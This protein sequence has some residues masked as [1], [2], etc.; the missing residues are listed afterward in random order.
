L[1]KNLKK[2]F[3][4]GIQHLASDKYSVN[5]VPAICTLCKNEEFE[6]SSLKLSSSI[7]DF[8]GMG[9]FKETATALIC[10]NCGQLMS[11]IGSVSKRSDEDV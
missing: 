3:K 9:L 8:L 7:L 10:R 4:A 5:N 1:F 6:R 11:F 2:G